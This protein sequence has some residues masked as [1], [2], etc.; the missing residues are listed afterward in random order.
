M[1]ITFLQKVSVCVIPG[2]NACRLAP[3]TLQHYPD[4]RYIPAKYE[5]YVI[6]YNVNIH[7][8]IFGQAKNIQPR[9][10]KK[11]SY[12]KECICGSL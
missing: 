11:Q 6:R 10:K 8:N 2:F 4:T 3:K 5:R 9:P 7:K 12:K 1:P